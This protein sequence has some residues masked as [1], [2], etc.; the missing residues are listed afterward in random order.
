[1]NSLIHDLTG[2]VQTLEI[3]ILESSLNVSTKTDDISDN[4]DNKG[5]TVRIEKII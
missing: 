1:M 3:L 2:L 4:S 5:I